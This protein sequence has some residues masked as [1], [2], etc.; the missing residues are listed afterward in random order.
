M[1][2]CPE[3]GYEYKEGIT[4]CPDCGAYLV[5]SLSEE[6]KQDETETTWV[7]LGTLPGNIY[8]EMLKEALEKEKIPLLIRGSALR[9]YMPS[10]TEGDAVTLLVPEKHRERSAQILHEMFGN[11]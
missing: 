11:L 9:A 5:N 3:C 4:Q 2:Y 8:A 10:G 6:E 7:K 1:A